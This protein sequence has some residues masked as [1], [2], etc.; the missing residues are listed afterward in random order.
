LIEKK[1][2]MLQTGSH[3]KGYLMGEDNVKFGIRSQLTRLVVDQSVK[4]LGEGMINKLHNEQGVE[5]DAVVKSNDDQSNF[6]D[7]LVKPGQSD[8]EVTHKPEAVLLCR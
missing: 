8:G 4:T 2:N 1:M 3:W 7:E 6:F 5:A